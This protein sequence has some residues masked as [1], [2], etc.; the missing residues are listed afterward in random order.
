MILAIDPGPQQS[1][2]VLFNERTQ[3]IVDKGV[4]DNSR[5]LAKVRDWATEG[6]TCAIEMVASYGMTVGAEVF[7]TCV[8][9][10]RFY[11]AWTWLQ[12]KRPPT[13]IYRKDVKLHL[14]GQT[15][16]VNDAVIRQRLI[17]LFGAPGRKKSQGPTYGMTSHMWPALAVAVTAAAQRAIA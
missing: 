11:E 2:Y 12:W 9:I 5:M 17:D 4:L 16:G 1:G 8:W 3:A 7:D 13:L 14:C 15:K 10:G 6:A